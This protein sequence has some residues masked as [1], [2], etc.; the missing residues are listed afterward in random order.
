VLHQDRSRANSFG[1]DPE[2]N[3]RVRPSYPPELI[4]RIVE[5][6]PST[7]LDVGCGTGIA[8]RLLAARGVQVLAGYPRVAALVSATRA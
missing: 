8:A 2:L 7:A 6:Q 3:D 5:R 4:D 1:D